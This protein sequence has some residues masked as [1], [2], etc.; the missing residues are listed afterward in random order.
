VIPDLEIRAAARADFAV[1]PAGI[2]GTSVARLAELLAAQARDAVYVAV[3]MA[4]AR[5]IG[6]GAVTW[7][8]PRSVEVAALHPNCAEIFNLG[9][10]AAWQGRGVGGLLL[11]HLEARARSRSCDAIGLGVGV[12]NSRAYSLYLRHGYRPVAPAQYA[13][14]WERVG[15]DGHREVHAEICVFLRKDVKPQLSTTPGLNIP[16][17]RAAP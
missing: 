4:S 5:P 15:T 7:S 2:A 16:A 13:D 6:V 1:L 8:G 10:E 9:V 17:P 3:A 14:R 11:Q 12:E